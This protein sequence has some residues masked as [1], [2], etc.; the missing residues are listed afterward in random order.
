MDRKEFIRTSGAALLL[1]TLG[2]PLQSCSEDEDENI[3][4]QDPN[5]DDD[6][7]GSDDDSDGISFNITES[8]F[9]VLETVDSWLLHPDENILILNAAGAIRAFTSVCTHSGCARDWSFA[10]A[11]ARCQC[12][13]SIFNQDGEVV[14]GPAGRALEEFSV[15]RD[16]DTVTV[17]V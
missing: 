5:D 9:N 14:Q 13:G 11:Q 8:P 12:H 17:S 7:E 15:S 10:N 4:P 16:G 1:A 3:T 6:D 2:I